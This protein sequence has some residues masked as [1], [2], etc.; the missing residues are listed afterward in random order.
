[1][2]DRRIALGVGR[3]SF[4]PTFGFQLRDTLLL[5]ALKVGVILLGDG[6]HN[7]V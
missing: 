2:Q 7:A 1:M 6:G 5:A 4:V 3:P